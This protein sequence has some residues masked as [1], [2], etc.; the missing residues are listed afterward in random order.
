MIF[1]RRRTKMNRRFQELLNRKKPMAAITYAPE[2][3]DST[4][5]RV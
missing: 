4:E 1:W 2:I 3:N 5:P